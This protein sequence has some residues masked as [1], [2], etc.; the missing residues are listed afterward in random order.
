MVTNVQVV[1]R[2]D[3]GHNY[4]VKVDRESGALVSMDTVH[5]RIHSGALY[6]L[7][8]IDLTLANNGTVETLIVV[9]ADLNVHLRFAAECGGD[10]RIQGYENTT[11]SDNGT[12]QT[13][14][15]RNRES[16]NTASFSVYASPT[17]TDDG[18]LLADGIILGGS[19]GKAIGGSAGSFEEWILPT[20]TY[21]FRLTNISGQSQIAYAQLDIYED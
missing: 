14:I 3:T 21:L 18:D 17:I 11:V 2:T 12:L 20:G 13:M 16:P 4:P 15:N 9:P 7:D 19:G 10:S 5:Q 6:S 8:F 1:G